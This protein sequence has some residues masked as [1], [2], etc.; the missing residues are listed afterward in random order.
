MA[1]RRPAKPSDV[2]RKSTLGDPEND[3]A[4]VGAAEEIVELTVKEVQERNKAAR[5]SILRETKQYYMNLAFDEG[6]QWIKWNKDD[7]AFIPWKRRGGRYQAT[8]NKLSGLKNTQVGKL[9]KQ[10]MV[11]EVPASQADDYAIEGSLLAENVIRAKHDRS[12]WESKRE[13]LFIAALLGGTAGVE[14]GWDQT[15]TAHGTDAKG[16]TVENVLTIADMAVEPGSRE[17]RTARWW[18]KN[19]VMPIDEAQS[20]FKLKKKPKAERSVAGPYK[21][22][23]MGQGDKVEKGVLVITYY[24]RPNHLRP[25]GAIVVVVGDEMVFNKPW[26]FPFKDHLNLD[27]VRDIVIPG[28]WYGSSRFSKA[29]SVQI[30]YNFVHSNIQDHIKALG[31]AK[32]A[33]PYGSSEVFEQ[34]D[35]NPANPLRYPDGSTPPHYIVAPPMP[36]YIIQQLDRLDAEMQDIMGIHGIST[37]EGVANVE[38]G[39][40]LSLLAE[41]DST[42][43]G[44]LAK[45]GARCWSNTASDVLELYAQNVVGTRKATVYEPKG[46]IAHCVKWT[47]KDLAGQTRAIIPPDTVIPHSRAQQQMFAENLAKMGYLP[48]D[49]PNSLT[50]LMELAQVPGREDSLWYTNPDEARA[51]NDIK[52]MMQGEVIIPKKWQ[53]HKNAIKVANR[54]RNTP[55]YESLPPK[56]QL[57]IDKYCEAHEAL[58]AEEAGEMTARAAQGGAPLAQAATANEST[59]LPP[60]MLG[61]AQQPQG[62]TLPTG[63]PGAAGMPLE[64]PTQGDSYGS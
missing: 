25:E 55:R 22:G 56:Q 23:I 20:R 32:L 8:V 6:H 33:A 62:G 49:D 47:G 3:K 48:P 50:L 54:F 26:P 7:R 16:D 51:R 45:D 5:D 39:Y 15:L 35:D 30:Q 9:L 59:P 29:L 2:E 14:T 61:L 19:Q 28:Q 17:A 1:L 57:V 46:K 64:Q 24:E 27:I 4:E 11:F 41:Q 34:M 18:T 40:G 63:E 37:G 42:P 58:D 21:S 43:T 53:N 38:S 12:D 52:R 36:G 60:E 44:R 31:T 10:E 13:E